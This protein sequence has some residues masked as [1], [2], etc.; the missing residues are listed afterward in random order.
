MLSLHSKPPFYTLLCDVE[1]GSH[2]LFAS[3][4]P[5]SYGNPG[6]RHES[7][8][9]ELAPSHPCC[10]LLI[11]I[12]ATMMLHPAA[13]ILP[14]GRNFHSPCINLMVSLLQNIP[15]PVCEYLGVQ[16]QVLQ[17]LLKVQEVPA[18]AKEHCSLQRSGSH[19]EAS[20]PGFKVE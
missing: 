15:A 19:C 4:I 2:F 7:K 13:A 20:A 5:V 6:G 1:S 11:N 10:L 9:R 8:R 14:V 12:I 17:G 3:Q 18:L 16:V